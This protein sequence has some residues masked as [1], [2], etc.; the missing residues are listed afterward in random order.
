MGR[1]K[2]A[3]EQVVL[4]DLRRTNGSTSIF[5]VTENR[6]TAAAFTRLEERGVIRR[7]RTQESGFPCMKF[8][9]EERL[10]N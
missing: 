9:I 7:D 5:A 4:A 1:T 10:L 3:W 2:A 8:I 6:F